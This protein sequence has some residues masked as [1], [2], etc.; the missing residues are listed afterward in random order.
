M[1]RRFGF[2]GY[3][4]V[5]DFKGVEYKAVNPLAVRSGL[6][7]RG[8]G[9]VPAI[10]L[11]GRFIGDSTEIAPAGRLSAAISVGRKALTAGAGVTFT[12]VT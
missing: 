7:R 2:I 12:S 9:K 4:Q 5:L 11:G 1:F 6:R 8:T 3:G 10:E